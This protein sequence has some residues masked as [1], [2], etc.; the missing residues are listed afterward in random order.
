M[1]FESFFTIVGVV[2]VVI[3]VITLV[4]VYFIYKL[5]KKNKQLID[6][7]QPEMVKGVKTFLKK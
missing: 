4:L 3:A 2:I 1:V 6:K 7:E 5:I